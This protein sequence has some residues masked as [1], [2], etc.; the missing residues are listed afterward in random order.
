MPA[1]KRLMNPARSMSLWL[2][3]SASAGAS[4]S[5]EMKNW[6]AFMRR[7]NG[8]TAGMRSG[9]G[10]RETRGFDSRNAS[11][12]MDSTKE[13][14]LI[15]LDREGFRPNVG[16]ILLNHRSEEIWGKPVR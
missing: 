11:A 9:A 14:R 5:V 13:L 3:T 8:R 1:D 15:M 12:I 6:L 7:R 10:V 16:I 4:L 2:T